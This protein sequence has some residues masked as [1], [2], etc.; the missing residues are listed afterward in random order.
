MRSGGVDQSARI[1]IGGEQSVAEI[2]SMVIKGNSNVTVKFD[3]AARTESGE[4][5]IALQLPDKF[6]KMVRIGHASDAI[7]EKITG[8]RHDIIVTSRSGEGSGTGV[9]AEPGGQKLIVKPPRHAVKSKRS[10]NGKDGELATSDE[11]SLFEK[12]TS[13]RREDSGTPANGRS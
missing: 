11:E 3:D 7:G 8:R 1:A 5:E 9:G 10:C 4:T 12:P 13:S 6:S 2:R